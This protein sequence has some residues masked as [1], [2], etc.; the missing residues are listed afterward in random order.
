MSLDGCDVGFDIGVRKI[1]VACVDPPYS[2]SIDLGKK[3]GERQME[4]HAMAD[5][6]RHIEIPPLSTCRVWIERP[7]L[8]SSAKINPDVSIHMGEVV[9][10]IRSMTTTAQRVTMVHHSA[11]KAAVLVN[12]KAS[13]A[14]IQYGIE[15]LWPELAALCM[16]IEDRYDAMG[17]ALYGKLVT[18]GIVNLPS[19]PRRPRAQGRTAGA[20]R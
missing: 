11:W 14:E 9:G 8:P 18:E 5:W 16:G 13:K 1:A 15:Q 19:K 3:A 2:N 12:G 20:G 4:I 10:L 6:L 7:Y 17:V